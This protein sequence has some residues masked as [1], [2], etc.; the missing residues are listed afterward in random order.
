M[1]ISSSCEATR[2]SIM[3]GGGDWETRHTAAAGGCLLRQHDQG[4]RKEHKELAGGTEGSLGISGKTRVDPY[5]L[6]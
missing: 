2:E 3:K 6:L 4:Q 1:T 5:L